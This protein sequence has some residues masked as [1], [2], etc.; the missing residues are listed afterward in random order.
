MSKL[1]TLLFG[2]SKKRMKPI[3]IDTLHKVELYKN[4]RE[5]TK[6]S[7]AGKGWHKVEIAPPDA[8]PWRIKTAS[9]G[10]NHAYSV[11]RV[12][13]GVGGY[14]NSFGFNPHT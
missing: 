3:M 7:A 5:A 4:A 1:Y 14:I 2:K 8:I 12:G 6:Q 9:R 10:E 11:G 13:H